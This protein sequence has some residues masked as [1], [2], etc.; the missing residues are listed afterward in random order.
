MVISRSFFL[1]CSIVN[2][3]R[4]HLL[5]SLLVYPWLLMWRLEVMLGVFYFLPTL[6]LLL[7]P[8]SLLVVVP[9]HAPGGQR[10]I[11]IFKSCF[12]LS[13]MGSRI[14]LEP[15]GLYG[16]HFYPPSPQAFSSP[17]NLFFEIES[18]P[19]HVVYHFS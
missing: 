8:L 7:L 10:T 11:L 12:C 4:K 9:R 6:L 16:K 17:S 13:T 19:K 2:L 1:H 18:F 5:P 15:S 14:E 3:K